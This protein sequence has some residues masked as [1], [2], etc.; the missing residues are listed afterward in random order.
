VAKFLT[1]EETTALITTMEAGAGD[2]LLLVADPDVRIVQHVLGLLRLE[3]GQPP[4]DEGGLHFLWVLE[5]PMFEAIGDDGK[6]IP[7]HHPFT[8]PNT[9]DLDLIESDPLKVRSQAYDLVVNGWELGSGSIRIH[10]PDIQQRVFSAIGLSDEQAHDRFGFLLG[11]FKYGAPP[12]GGFAFGTDR[13]AAILAGEENIREVI[14]FPKTQSGQ[15]PLTGAPAAIEDGALTEY[16]LRK[17]P[18]KA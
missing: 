18:P 12:H 11:A 3:L 16:G 7:A 8:M 14:A 4:L 15:D 1:P 6:P 13:L 10:R 5:F 9:D 2:L 17:L